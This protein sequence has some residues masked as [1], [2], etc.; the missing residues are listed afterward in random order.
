MA[1]GKAGKLVFTHL[2]STDFNFIDFCYWMSGNNLWKSGSKKS[3]RRRKE[4]EAHTLNYFSFFQCLHYI[5]SIFTAHFEWTQ[6]ANHTFS[7]PDNIC[8]ALWI[9]SYYL[10]W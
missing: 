3:A 8:I 4:T 2:R 6:D 1:P 7:I 9:K 10:I 5:N